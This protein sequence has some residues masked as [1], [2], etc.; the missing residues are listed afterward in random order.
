MWNSLFGWRTQIKHLQLK[1][2]VYHS[3]GKRAAPDVRRMSTLSTV[4]SSMGSNGSNGP[5]EVR[6]SLRASLQIQNCPVIFELIL[7]YTLPMAAHYVIV[8]SASLLTSNSRLRSD[9]FQ[10][11]VLLDTT[12]LMRYMSANLHSGV[13]PAQW[14]TCL[15]V[16][17]YGDCFSRNAVERVLGVELT[18]FSAASRQRTSI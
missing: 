14:C 5:P 16:T 11:S 8:P 1:S 4:T 15:A 10:S 13:Q 6:A 12:H 17:S 3:G 9:N 18:N 7:K 2:G